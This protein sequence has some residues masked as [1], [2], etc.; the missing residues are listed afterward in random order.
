MLFDL[1]I[2]R[3]LN[4]IGNVKGIRISYKMVYLNMIMY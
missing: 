4:K 3:I 2:E 1:I